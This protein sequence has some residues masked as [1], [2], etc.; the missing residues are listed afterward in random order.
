M[1]YF[2]SQAS[3]RASA[4]VNKDRHSGHPSI[5]PSKNEHDIIKRGKSVHGKGMLNWMGCGLALEWGSK[6]WGKIEIRQ[7]VC[8]RA[9]VI[10]R[11]G[12]W[13][14]WCSQIDIFNQE[15]DNHLKWLKIHRYPYKIHF[16][17]WIK[18]ELTFLL[19]PKSEDLLFEVSGLAAAVSCFVRCLI[20]EH[21]YELLLYLL[22]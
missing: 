20:K 10:L 14:R 22:F 1:N 17:H 13:K 4:G 8:P 6:G 3:L 16:T 7:S 5:H 18:S 12:H 19:N 2:S 11:N 15:M 21:F 9:K